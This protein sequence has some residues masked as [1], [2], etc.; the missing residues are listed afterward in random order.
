MTIKVQHT[1]PFGD[2]SASGPRS[3]FSQQSKRASGRTFLG[4][5]PRLPTL[6][7]T[8]LAL[9]CNPPLANSTSPS[10]QGSGGSDQSEELK[11]IAEKDESRSS[12][13]AKD[14]TKSGGDLP[15]HG[16]FPLDAEQPIGPEQLS[17]H[18]AEGPWAELLE[19]LSTGQNEQALKALRLLEEQGIGDSEISEVSEV[20]DVLEVSDVSDVSDNSS[21]SRGAGPAPQ[22][23]PAK[24]SAGKARVEASSKKSAPPAAH[25]APA[26]YLQARVLSAAGQNIE[27]ARAFELAASHYE[28]SRQTLLAQ[29]SRCQ[30]VQQY[31]EAEDEESALRLFGSCLNS[32]LSAHRRSPLLGQYLQQAKDHQ[33]LHGLL[34]GTLGAT[35]RASSSAEVLFP[36]A[37]V[38]EAAGNLEEAI[39]L[40]KRAWTQD[41][42]SP[43]SAEIEEK[44]EALAKQSPAAKLGAED[45]LA[46]AERFY[47]LGDRRSAQQRL[48]L[49]RQPRLCTSN[50]SGSAGCEPVAC[51]DF[52]IGLRFYGE[53]EEPERESGD[54]TSA[55]S[56]STDAS[57]AERRV[58]GRGS[59]AQ[60][61][62]GQGSQGSGEPGSPA[63]GFVERGSVEEGSA[64][65]GSAEQSSAENSLSEKSPAKQQAKFTSASHSP[66]PIGPLPLPACAVEEIAAPAD[67]LVCR[68]EF[69]EA[70]LLRSNRK[71]TLA[72]A[73]FRRVY[74][75]CSD[76][77]LR[78]RAL[79]LAQASATAIRHADAMGLA[80]LLALQ[81]PESS[82]GDDALMAAA[83][84]ARRL[85]D[86]RRERAL[87][88]KIVRSYPDGDQRGTALFQLFWSYRNEGQT[89]SG[90]YALEIL[91]NEHDLDAGGVG[92][93]AERGRYWWG[94]SVALEA[95]AN[96]REQGLSVLA[97][98]ARERPLTYYGVLARSFLDHYAPH[99]DKGRRTPPPA[100]NSASTLRPGPLASEPLLQVGLELLRMG[101][102]DEARQALSALPLGQLDLKDPAARE[103][104]IL[105]AQLLAHG[106]NQVAAH[107]LIRFTM[108]AWIRSSEE[109]VAAL[110]SRLAYPLA[111]REHISQYSNAHGVHADFVQGLMREESSLDPRAL[112]PV[113]A[114]GLTQLMPATAR[115][116]ATSLG[117][118]SF[119]VESL[120]EPALNIRFGATYLSRMLQR[121]G[122]PVIA[123]AAYNAGPT[124]V[125]RWMSQRGDLPLDEFVENIPYA[126]TQGYVKR[127]LRSYATYRYLYGDDGEEL[128]SVSMS[129][130]GE[131]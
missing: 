92:A 81:F 72:T 79:F 66:L 12:L 103:A 70:Q 109:P 32:P 128:L 63:Q 131:P 6:L 69:L 52:D 19:L 61:S 35:L 11:G 18:F 46:R 23:L 74:Q 91:A 126:E 87:L 76:P 67:S 90:L 25:L 106:G 124:A 9:A 33:E 48:G 68:A 97:T 64:E 114:R 75:R 105:V 130:K 47:T 117:I 31:E 26:H 84:L 15:V 60:G 38:E 4:Q 1:P 30:A 5:S 3:T 113:G 120:W 42:V 78:V 111:Y 86:P 119:D 122:H 36:L 53:P 88:K 34:E 55:H 121:F 7:L 102:A 43:R 20:S 110:A 17:P 22:I 59:K 10:L 116:V 77:D 125:G 51:G 107:A 85:E 41:P 2:G 39:A 50:D 54:R 83:T 40:L 80:W 37:L 65:Q 24:A 57:P 118:R 100:A 99:Y 129:L 62:V 93:D 27:S 71:H 56:S 16:T 44:L 28:A 89:A 73:S 94:R 8:F 98:L 29:W 104:K 108:P 95:A 49:A 82:L 14:A 96:E 101:L 45:S 13:R 127:V 123:A 112:S 21:D 115:Q 58:A